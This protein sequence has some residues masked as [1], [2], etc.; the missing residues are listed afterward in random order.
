MDMS[1]IVANM[2]NQG[3]ELHGQTVKVSSQDHKLRKITSLASI[4]MALALFC[5]NLPAQAQ[6]TQPA[7][8]VDATAKKQSAPIGV[9]V[10][11]DYVLGTEDQITITSTS[12]KEINFTGVQVPP[13]GKINLPLLG[14]FTVPGKT[15]GQLQAEIIRRMQREG[16]LRPNATVILSSQRKQRVF[17]LNTDGTSGTVELAPGMRLSDVLALSGG[18]RSMRPE[19][20]DATLS[21][22]GVSRP[23]TLDLVSVVRDSNSEANIEIKNGDTI[24]LMPR[25]IEVS[26]AGSV[27]RSGPSKIPIGSTITEAMAIAGG[28][29]VKAA[30]SRATIK[31][32]GDGTLIPI[33]LHDIL[34]KGKPA[35]DIEL[36]EG[37]LILVPEAQE[38]VTV[39]GAVGRPGYFPIEDGRKLLISELI[40]QAGGPRQDASL[41]RTV[42][43]RADGTTI[44]VNLY[45]VL[46]LNDAESNIELKPDD[47]VT[48]PAYREQVVVAGTGVRSGGFIPI[49]EGTTMRILDALIKSGGLTNEPVGT[50]IVITRNMPGAVPSLT[51][52]ELLPAP[53]TLTVDP[54]RLYKEN[55]T[56]ANIPLQNGD[57]IMVTALPRAVFLSGH[58]KNPGSRML[59][60]GVGLVELLAEAG[61]VTETG[62]ASGVIVERNGNKHVVD[63]FEA[64][65]EG[66]TVNFPLEA[67]DNIIV[68]EN[69]NRVAVMPGVSRPGYIVIPEDKPISLAEAMVMAGGPR[70]TS[71]LDEVTLLRPV[72]GQE[73]Q[74]IPAPLRNDKQWVAASKIMLQPGD[75]V[76]V[77]DR[78]PQRPRLLQR[79][80][81]IV[82]AFRLFGLPFP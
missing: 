66:E 38:Q 31:R 76:Y 45:R 48:V 15:I 56:D 65:T 69:K 59:K 26:F 63:V 58:V 42:V 35:P 33:N 18:M 44:N 17:M 32:A 41:T 80:F 51:P 50:S 23:I 13:D 67:G 53:T 22:L 21:R 71:K 61:G 10:T 8:K 55:D 46:S 9:V 25:I 12:H 81:S 79:L 75:I 78:E 27:V 28:P 49:I 70:D 52:Q 73:M 77:P 14:Q 39:Q 36:R 64:L 43:Q 24:R 74:R 16:F 2:K 7:K 34:I 54:V 37:D 1:K 6:T 57:L 30:L 62:L 82:P 5:A 60:E 19:L 68:P 47:I 3:Y 20:T 4:A 72:P 40:A 11:S 29:T